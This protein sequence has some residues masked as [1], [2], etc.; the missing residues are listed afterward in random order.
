MA[1]TEMVA[2]G[3]RHPRFFLPSS[4]RFCRCYEEEPGCGANFSAT[5]FMQ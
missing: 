5:P 2:S 3:G 1:Y 4:G